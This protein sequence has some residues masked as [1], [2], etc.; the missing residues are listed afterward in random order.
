MQ[1]L[2]GGAIA[3]IDDA[4]RRGALAH[5]G[6]AAVADGDKLDTVLARYGTDDAIAESLR[7]H[8]QARDT[9]PITRTELEWM[10]ST[11]VATIAWLRRYRDAG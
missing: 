7:E 11:E 8:A 3:A 9:D 5:F 6:A 10:A 2:G 4:T 1:A